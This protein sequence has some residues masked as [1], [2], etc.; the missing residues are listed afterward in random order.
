MLTLIIKDNGEPSVVKY[1]YEQMF[2][3]VK[4]IPDVEILV[5]PTW[6][7]SK[8]KNLYVCLLEADCLVNS[9]Y[10]TSML[11]LFQKN[12]MF[13][14]LAMLSSSV[15]V[16]QWHNKF[17]GYSIE[18]EYADGVV[19]IRDKKSRAVYPVQIGYIP[20][21]II[22]T[23]MLQEAIKEDGYSDSWED[24]LVFLSVQLS[25]CFWRQGDGNPVHINPNTTYVTTEDYVNDIGRFPVDAGHLV[26][27][28]SKESI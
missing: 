2:K 13:R 24:D 1:T 4:D 27:M 7:V 5:Q 19:P 28:F 20:G 23:K 6:D 14:K 11:G 16:N 9:G 15:A 10:F 18:D 17:Y 8:V 21:A 22:R 3:E 26:E 12:K 25:L